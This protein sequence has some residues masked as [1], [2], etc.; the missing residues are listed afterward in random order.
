V[1]R[2]DLPPGEVH[3][4]HVDLDAVGGL[5][6][7]AERLAHD[8]RERAARF[9]AERDAARFVAG[10]ATLRSLLGRYLGADPWEL[11]F[12]YGRAGKPSLVGHEEAGLCFNVA[13]SGPL[14]LFAVSAGADVGVDVERLR[15]VAELERLAT[16]YLSPADAACLAAAAPDDRL[17]VFL[18]GWARKE[19]LVK[20]LG[21]GMTRAHLHEPGDAWLVESWRPWADAV[22][23]LAVRGRDWRRV[24]RTLDRLDGEPGS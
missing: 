3:V 20:A 6:A 4:W 5:A 13:H 17:A 12:R 7:L 9:R 16:R 21:E 19:A 23:A 18:E 8:E 15:P 14:A 1:G 24:D 11:A 10:R 22:A 2:L